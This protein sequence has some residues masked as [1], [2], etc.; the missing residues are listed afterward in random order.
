[1]LELDLSGRDDLKQLSTTDLN[2]PMS[3]DRGF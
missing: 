3:K 2:L 1:M